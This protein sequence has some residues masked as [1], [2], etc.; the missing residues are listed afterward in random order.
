MKTFFFLIFPIKLSFRFSV[1]S[2][3]SEVFFPEVDH[4]SAKM[5]WKKPRQLNGILIGYRLI[6]WRSDDE[7]TRIIIDNLTETTQ[8][9]L[10]HGESNG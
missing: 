10:A 4:W 9:Y 7:Q 3:P 1:P 8:I 6:Y 2:K 5:V